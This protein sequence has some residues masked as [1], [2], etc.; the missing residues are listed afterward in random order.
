MTQRRPRTNLK[1]GYADIDQAKY[2]ATRNSR[3]NSKKYDDRHDNPLSFDF[4]SVS[5]VQLSQILDHKYSPYI[6]IGVVV[7]IIFLIY[8]IIAAVATIFLTRQTAFILSPSS[9]ATG[10]QYEGELMIEIEEVVSKLIRIRKSGNMRAY[11]DFLQPVM[12]QYCIDHLSKSYFAGHGA[13]SFHM[14]VADTVGFL[15]R[16]VG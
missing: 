4:N 14:N 10:S 7:T 3:W 1:K 12:H 2:G 6:L 16:G 15:S 9:I 11:E 13:E 5:K 8:L